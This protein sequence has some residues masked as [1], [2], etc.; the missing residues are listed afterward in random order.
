MIKYDFAKYKRLLKPLYYVSGKL[1]FLHLFYPIK[2]TYTATSNWKMA[3]LYIFQRKNKNNNKKRLF[4]PLRYSIQHSI[5]NYLELQNKCWWPLTKLLYLQVPVVCNQRLKI[6]LKYILTIHYRKN[7]LLHASSFIQSSSF[8]QFAIIRTDTQN[9]LF[10]VTWFF[11]PL[12]NQE[13]YHS[14]G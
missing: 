7:S 11:W 6:L 3:K 9:F 4:L 12:K 1:K 13:P 5:L 2:D 8:C 14:P 10:H